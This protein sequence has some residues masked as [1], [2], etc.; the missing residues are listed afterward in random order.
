MSAIMVNMSSAQP[1]L[2]QTWPSSTSQVQ[3]ALP[4]FLAGCSTWQYAV[5]FLLSVVIYDQ[6]N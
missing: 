3:A 2:P 1:E 4:A 5:T 6:G